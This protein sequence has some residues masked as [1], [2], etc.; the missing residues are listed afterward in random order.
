MNQGSHN[1]HGFLGSVV[2]FAEHYEEVVTDP[3]CLG[4]MKASWPDSSTQENPVLPSPIPTMICSMT[5]IKSQSCLYV[6]ELF[7]A[8]GGTLTSSGKEKMSKVF[9]GFSNLNTP[10]YPHSDPDLNKDSDKFLEKSPAAKPSLLAEFKVRKQR[11]L[12]HRK[13]LY[14]LSTI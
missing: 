4:D 3:N 7:P 5:F 10:C 9:P 6:T 12:D 2:H 1:H 8:T 14:I 11:D 13:Y